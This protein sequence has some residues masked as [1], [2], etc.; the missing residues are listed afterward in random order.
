MKYHV[1]MGRFLGVDTLKLSM[2][3]KKN[4]STN[5]IVFDF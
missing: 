2:G 4:D 3:K 1:K 5:A